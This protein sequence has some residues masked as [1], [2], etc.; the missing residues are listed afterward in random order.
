[1]VNPKMRLC[2]ITARG[3]QCL[4]SF[5]FEEEMEVVSWF[6]PGHHKTVQMPLPGLFFFCVPVSYWPQLSCLL[7]YSTCLMQPRKAALRHSINICRVNE[8]T[9]LKGQSCKRCS[10]L[11]V[12][13]LENINYVEMLCDHLKEHSR[14][15]KQN[16]ILSRCVSGS[17]R[18][19]FAFP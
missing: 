11:K 19:G 8:L 3:I 1:M 4:S 16:K 17:G 2:L 7:L 13:N 14:K 5:A 15:K 18:R 10:S 6:S 9:F 12:Y